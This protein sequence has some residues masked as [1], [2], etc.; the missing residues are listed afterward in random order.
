MSGVYIVGAGPGHPDYL[1]SA[2]RKT[3]AG[4][5][6]LIGGARNLALF[7]DWSG[8]KIEITNNLDFI[9]SYLVEHHLCK[10]IAILVTGD[11]GLFSM[12]QTIQAR[13][14]NCQLD[15]IPGISSLQY[16]AAKLEM[17]WHDWHIISLH[18]KEAGNILP[19][20]LRYRRICFFTGGKWTPETICASLMQQG[21]SRARVWVG[22][23][24]SYPQERM[25]HGSVTDISRQ[26]FESLSLMLMEVMESTTPK[27]PFQTPGI[28]DAMFIQGEVPLTKAEVR[29]VSLAKLRLQTGQCVYDIGAGTGTVAVEC[30]LQ[31]RESSVYAIEKESDALGLIAQNA[32]LFGVVNL[33]IIAGEAPEAFDGLPAPDRVFIGGSGGRLLP[34]LERLTIF[35]QPLR[36]VI[37]A[38]TIETCHAALS[39][40]TSHGFNEIEVVHLSVARGKNAGGRHLMQALNPIFIISAALEQKDGL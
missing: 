36:V 23:N 31:C 10:N 16:M 7:P 25:S 29:A 39:G 1:T 14:P 11:P 28:P 6:V 20:L 40:L 21:F 37:N 13:L 12:L 2:A 22:E 3:I 35:K 38:V 26:H 18:G 30:A 5:Q 19:E 27:W 9:C 24:L 8:L 4:C 17:A 33:Q 15:V 34:I 32:T